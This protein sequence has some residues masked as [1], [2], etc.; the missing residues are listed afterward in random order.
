[1]QYENFERLN[2]QGVLFVAIHTLIIFNLAV[3]FSIFY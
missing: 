1:M 2:K 3:D